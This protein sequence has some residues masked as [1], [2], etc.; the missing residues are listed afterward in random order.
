MKTN[1]FKLASEMPLE[2]KIRG[3]IEHDLIGA[4]M[5]LAGGCSAERLS[6]I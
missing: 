6:R 5:P 2:P 4:T 3:I 1:I